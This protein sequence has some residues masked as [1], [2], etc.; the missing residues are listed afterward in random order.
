MPYGKRKVRI[1]RPGHGKSGSARV[2]YYYYNEYKP[3]LLLLI[4][5]KAKQE[6]LTSGQ[7][8]RLKKYVKQLIDKFG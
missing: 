8:T 1:A 4:Y 5:T 7:K 3:I 2:I 6:N